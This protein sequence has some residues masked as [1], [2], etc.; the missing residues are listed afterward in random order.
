VR[1]EYRLIAV[2]HRDIEGSGER[3]DGSKRNLGN[4]DDTINSYIVN[5]RKFEL[6][7]DI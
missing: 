1:G 3:K 7:E 6:R 5:E 2:V 4:V